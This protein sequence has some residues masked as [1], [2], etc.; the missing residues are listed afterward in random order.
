VDGESTARGTTSGSVSVGPS[1]TNS[2]AGSGSDSQPGSEP[3]PTRQQRPG[4]IASQADSRMS[5][6]IPNHVYTRQADDNSQ[7]PLP[8]PQDDSIIMRAR[9]YSSPGSRDNLDQHG[10]RLSGLREGY[11][12]DVPPGF[13]LLA[14]SNLGD[15]RVTMAP[16]SHS[17]DGGVPSIV[18]ILNTA[19]NSTRTSVSSKY[20]SGTP[21]LRT[22]QSST[23]ST[24]SL[25]SYAPPRTPSE[26]SLPIH[27]LLSA[28]P[29]T[30]TPQ[31]GA[32]PMS[33]GLVPSQPPSIPPQPL[34]GRVLDQ[35]VDGRP[36]YSSNSVPRLDHSL[37]PGI[38]RTLPGTYPSITSNNHLPPV[39]PH[40]P[41]LGI[42]NEQPPVLSNP[43]LDG[44]NALLRASDIVGRQTQ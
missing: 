25:N 4:S 9:G 37:A 2:N 10:R 12:P 1:A 18:P 3:P 40:H 35:P 30:P 28:K 29:E 17:P 22:D 20:W 43:G 5:P 26:S 15:P 21:S 42:T 38:N 41:S 8:I 24:T 6:V 13:G 16:V 11:R 34:P 7:S 36:P 33:D 39:T 14:L 44:M 27:A 32:T 19:S 23:G 31:T